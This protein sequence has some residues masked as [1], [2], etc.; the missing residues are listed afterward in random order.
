MSAKIAQINQTLEASNEAARKLNELTD[1]FILARN[2][3]V[4]G[5]AFYAG[6]TILRKYIVKPFL[7]TFKFL[8]N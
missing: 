6:W 5:L 7:N 4:G 2:I 3:I 1:N 8:S